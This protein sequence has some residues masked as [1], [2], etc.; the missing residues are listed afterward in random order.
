MA[1]KIYLFPIQHGIH[2]ERS[3]LLAKMR[4]CLPKVAQMGTSP[5][6]I[7]LWL[8]QRM[9]KK[10]MMKML[11]GVSSVTNH[12]CMTMMTIGE[13]IFYIIPFFKN[14]NRSTCYHQQLQLSLISFYLSKIVNRIYGFSMSHF[15]HR[16]LSR[17]P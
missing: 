7:A 10:M 16:Y 17:Y 6:L 11:M 15:I 1:L 8:N 4:Q 2:E 13:H 3:A 14:F 5:N 12:T 9:P